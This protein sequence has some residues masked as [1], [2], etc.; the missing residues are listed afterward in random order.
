MRE[1]KFKVW[2]KIHKIMFIPEENPFYNL[3]FSDEY[4]Y[5]RGHYFTGGEDTTD[6][7]ECDLEF[8]QYIGLKDKKRTKDY[9]MGQEIYEEDIVKFQNLVGIIKWREDT[10]GFMITDK[11][12]YVF[13]PLVKC[14]VIGNI[15][16][17]PELIKK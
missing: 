12:G 8:L 6:H 16:Q 4:G 3:R 14:E 10:C 9:P 11:K 15:H 5:F 17:N 2:D 13:S 1:I 7:H